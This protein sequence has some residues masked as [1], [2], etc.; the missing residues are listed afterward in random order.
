VVLGT[1]TSTNENNYSNLKSLAGVAGSIVETVSGNEATLI[2]DNNTFVKLDSFAVVLYEKITRQAKTPLDQRTK[3]AIAYFIQNGTQT[4]KVLGAGERAGVLNSYFSVYGKLPVSIDDWKD[5]IKIANGR[6]PAQKNLVAESNS[7][8]KYFVKIYGRI[9]K[10]ADAH[11]NAAV[12]VIAYGLRPANRNMNSEN[13]ANKIF[14]SVYGHR[15]NS[16]SDWDLVRAIA[17]SGATR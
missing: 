15:P 16:A 3:Y 11:D 9:A 17:Y 5:V 12:S 4:T 7:A 2:Y 1:E 6:W 10:M 14:Q 8:N 13:A